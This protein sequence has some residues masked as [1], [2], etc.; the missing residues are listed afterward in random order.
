M[1]AGLTTAP[2]PF[3]REGVLNFVA[4]ATSLKAFSAP[5]LF[6]RLLSDV[7]GAW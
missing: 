3:P 7:P 5:G 6:S 4:G 1:L 2:T